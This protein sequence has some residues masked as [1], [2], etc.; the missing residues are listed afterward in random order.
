MTLSLLWLYHVYYIT[1]NTMLKSLK[2][3]VSSTNVIF[4]E[5]FSD[6]MLSQA[7]AQV[8]ALLCYYWNDVV[9]KSLSHNVAV[10]LLKTAEWCS[11]S[12]Q[13]HMS[14]NTSND[15]LHTNVRQQLN[16]AWTQVRIIN[17]AFLP[18]SALTGEAGSIHRLFLQHVRNGIC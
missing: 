13:W 16:S 8:F 10:D 18:D 6:I 3:F 15:S 4:G 7:C 9:Y 1:Y 2:I 11:R 14:H 12:K 17:R 5:S